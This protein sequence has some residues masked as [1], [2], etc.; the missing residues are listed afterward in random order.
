[1][2]TAENAEDAEEA[3]GESRQMK[4]EGEKTDFGT[5]IAE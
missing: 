1:L 3:G 4:D 5:L 2:F